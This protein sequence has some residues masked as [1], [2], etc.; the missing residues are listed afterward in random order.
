MLGAVGEGVGVG[1]GALAAVNVCDNGGLAG[2][3][4][5]AAGI[6]HRRDVCGRDDSVAEAADGVKTVG[7]GDGEVFRRHMVGVDPGVVGVV[8]GIVIDERGIAAAVDER[9]SVDAGFQGD[10]HPAVGDAGQGGGV[11]LGEAVDIGLAVLRGR[12]GCRVEGVGVSPQGVVS[13]AVGVAIAEDD[14]SGAVGVD[15]GG[16]VHK[17][18]RDGVAAGVGDVGGSRVDGV[19]EAGHGGTA[20]VGHAGDLVGHHDME[21]ERPGGV[22]TSAVLV[23]EG[24]GFRSYTIFDATGN[25]RIRWWDCLSAGICNFGQ[26]DVHNRR[27]ILTVYNTFSRH[28]ADVECGGSVDDDELLNGTLVSALVGDFIGT[29]DGNITGI[30]NHTWFAV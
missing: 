13:G 16:A 2:R 27:L 25:G 19:H 10:G 8:D 18:G 22:F 20:V 21:G 1:H 4:R 9:G 12:E 11:H 26:V 6:G 17:D 5:V 15:S 30:S 29:C 3:E 24:E 14:G 7:G 23:A 28:L